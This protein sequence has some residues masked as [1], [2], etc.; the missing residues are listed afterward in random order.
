ML[1]F[2]LFLS[3]TI[4]TFHFSAQ[5]SLN[6]I[7]FIEDN[8]ADATSLLTDNANNV[9]QLSTRSFLSCYYIT[10]YRPDG[11]IDWT[12]ALPMTENQHYQYS[13]IEGAQLSYDQKDGLYLSGSYTKGVDFDPDTS[14]VTLP[15]YGAFTLKID[16][17]GK[18]QWVFGKG[19]KLTITKDG[20]VITARYFE[21]QVLDP[22]PNTY[23]IVPGKGTNWFIAKYSYER[24]LL[25]AKTIRVLKHGYSEILETSADTDGNLFLGQNFSDTI[26]ISD[27]YKSVLCLPSS[28]SST[29]ISMWDTNGKIIWTKTFEDG[30]Y[31]PFHLKC[32]SDGIIVGFNKMYVYDRDP[33]EAYYP[34]AAPTTIIYRFSKTGNVVWKAAFDEKSGV[35]S[36]LLDIDLDSGENIYLT[37]TFDGDLDFDPGPAKH[38]IKNPA[39]EIRPAYGDWGTYIVKWDKSGNF[40][41]AGAIG[42]Q[43]PIALTCGNS[44]DVFLY[45]SFY[46]VQDF[47]PGPGTYTVDAGYAGPYTGEWDFYFANITC[48]FLP[49]SIPNSISELPLT[50]YPNPVENNLY[51]KSEKKGTL[52]ISDQLGKLVS[53]DKIANAEVVDVTALPTGIYFA[54]LKSIDGRVQYFKF[55]KR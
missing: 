12:Y 20:F 30:L 33:G 31:D 35:P 8:E 17:S 39:R 10:K 45:G 22:G 7:Q 29:F 14:V 4:L 46:W 21:Q 43:R 6:W 27:A 34:M 38:I 32:I 48:D 28:D 47:D 49:T 42:G 18:F 37:G 50:F 13:Y 9:Y 15:G 41:C 40:L 44:S 51:V 3:L 19:G 36:K 11:S 55:I 5:P 25:W 26:F 53:R 24:Q 23:S 52:T 1:R 54:S 16:T 2:H